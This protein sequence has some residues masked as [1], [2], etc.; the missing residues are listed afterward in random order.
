MTAGDSH[1]FG[2][3]SSGSSW[4]ID[5]ILCCK[6]K[7]LGSEFG[8]QTAHHAIAFTVTAGRDARA[9][10]SDGLLDLKVTL[11]RELGGAN[12]RGV[13]PEHLF[14]ACYAVSLLGMMRLVARRNGIALPTG[15]EVEATVG[16]GPS[17]DSL[18]EKSHASCPYANATRGNVPVRLVIG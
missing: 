5:G 17:A 18:V 2:G 12:G 1:L 11:R 14:A 13:E 7:I 6:N 8:G 15:T 9:V 10:S 3:A 16:V 4:C